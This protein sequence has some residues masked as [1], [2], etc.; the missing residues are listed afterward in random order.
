[1]IPGSGASTRAVC[2]A[3][4]DV[5]VVA[6]VYRNAATL[7]SLVRRIHDAFDRDG[8]DHVVLLVDDGSPDDAWD[9]IQDICRRDA[10]VAGARLDRNYG[11][12]TAIL[13]GLTLA[14]SAWTAVMDADL[15]DP[16]EALPAL[17][18]KAHTT[19]STVFGIRVARHGHWLRRASSATYK[20]LLTVLAGVPAG[21]GTFFVV[22]A[23]VVETVT[24]YKVSRPQVLVMTCNASPRVT[25]LGYIRNSREI[26]ES[27]YDF[28]SLLIAALNGLRCALE[29]RRGFGTS[30]V[31][32]QSWAG[33]G[34][35]A[36]EP[37]QP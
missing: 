21:C 36:G 20:L 29:C 7:E 26:G 35:L 4:H 31:H 15:Q 18:A 2:L 27:A 3:R 34:G 13:L 23:E 17:V 6:P 22:P 8:T 9:V 28:R 1:V 32:A 37:W 12:H 10:R 19:R 16:P 11:Q 14:R 30:K 25:T 24:R 33:I 5:T